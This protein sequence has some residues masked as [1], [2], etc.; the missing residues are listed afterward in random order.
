M[1]NVRNVWTL[2][3]KKLLKTGSKMLKELYT[4]HLKILD[5]ISY[6]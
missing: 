3:M 2:E 4:K 1:W 6:F 5:E